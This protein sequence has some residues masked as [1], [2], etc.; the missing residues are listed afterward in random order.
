MVC[1][2]LGRQ[3]TRAVAADRLTGYAALNETRM[4][5]GLQDGWPGCFLS[6]TIKRIDKPMR[7]RH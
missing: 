2:L 1:E 4:N 7:A 6:I 3:L 5:S